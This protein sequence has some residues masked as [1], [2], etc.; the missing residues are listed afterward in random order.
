MERRQAY[1]DRSFGVKSAIALTCA[2]L[3]SNERGNGRRLSEHI[4]NTFG[5]AGERD[6]SCVTLAR[7]DLHTKGKPLPEQNPQFVEHHSAFL[8]IFEAVNFCTS[9]SRQGF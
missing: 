8:G 1:H 3:A 5:T 2:T 7:T 9:K 4:R 6:G